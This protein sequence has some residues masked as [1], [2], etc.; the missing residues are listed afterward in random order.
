[1]RPIETSMTEVL[2][3]GSDAALRRR[4]MVIDETLPGNL[5]FGLT[6]E[7]LDKLAEETALA[8]VRRF[9]PAARVVT[10]AIDSIRVRNP[11][12]VSRDLRF[13]AR[14]NHVGRTS[15]E[16]GIRVE[17]GGDAPRH[18][19]SCYFT[20]VARLGEKS[21]AIPQLEYVDELE[22][23]R[24]RRALE[25]RAKVRRQEQEALE[26][27]TREEYD[28]LTRL[29]GEQEKPDFDGLLARDLF[30]ES[31]ERVY[32]EQ[33]NV[34]QKIFGGYLMHR[35]YQLASIHSEKIAS[36]RTVVVAV[37]RINFLRPVRIGDTLHFTSR[38][39]FGGRTSIAVETRIERIGWEEKSVKDLSNNCVFTFVNVENDLR[40]Q[41]VPSIFP[42][43]YDED[44]RYLAA[45]R[46]NRARAR[47]KEAS[48][49][50]T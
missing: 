40:P 11:A 45:Y 27:P 49:V 38:I 41:P 1:M 15:L 34:P 16:V 3:L 19:A 5:R 46:R 28:M 2:R 42:T 25:R 50:G 31:W 32:L 24:Q 35:A 4:F 6:L 23:R 39:V 9:E 26:P 12:D 8:Y 37:N 14:V 48:A 44:A 33:E 43:T 47:Y 13:L 17:Q 29:H 7:V 21:I 20:M 18:I 10:A 30:A 22:V 36:H